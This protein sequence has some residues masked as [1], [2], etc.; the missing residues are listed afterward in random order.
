MQGHLQLVLAPSALGKTHIHENNKIFMS[1]QINDLKPDENTN[2][3]ETI[4]AFVG[5]DLL[6]TEFASSTLFCYLSFNHNHKR[7]DSINII[8]V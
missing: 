6:P 1:I 5:V 3:I 7:I 2:W 8:N 4:R